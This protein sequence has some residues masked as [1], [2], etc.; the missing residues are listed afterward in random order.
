MIDFSLDSCRV[1]ESVHTLIPSCDDEYSFGNEERRSFLRGWNLTNGTKHD[2]NSSI[3]QA[4]VYRSSDEI[5]TYIYLGEH[6]TYRSGGYVYEL[7]GT[8]NQTHADLLELHQLEWIDKQTRAVLIQMNL[9]NPSIPIF[10]SAIIII[11]LLPSSGVF[12][13]A[14][15]EPLYF[16]CILL[17]PL[18]MLLTLIS[19][20]L[21]FSFRISLSNRLRCDLLDLH[22]LFPGHGNSL[23]Y[24]PS[25]G[26]L[27][28]I[29]VLYWTGCDRLF[30]GGCRYPYVASQWSNKDSE[31]ISFDQRWCLR[32]FPTNCLHQR[33]FLLSTGILLLFWNAEIA[34]FMPLQ[35]SV[36][37]LGEYIETGDTRTAL[38][39]L[40]VFHHFHGFPGTLLLA[41][42]FADMG[43]LQPITYCSNALWNASLEVW[44][45]WIRSGWT[46]L[47]SHLFHLIHSL[48]C[49]R[50]HQYVRVDHQWQF[51]CRSG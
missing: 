28:S 35:P 8:L 14:R 30:M 12:P 2:Y 11:E 4:F 19:V 45:Q 44:H 37:S 16:N 46:L 41:I 3:D 23:V 33:R 29:L 13:S 51:P 17:F 40:H 18:S 5:D 26:V 20:V 21:L 31:V 22:H 48:R 27:S 1:K 32:E 47:R 38:I 7:R 43:M 9:Y 15:F 49:F 24:S 50:L 42:R 25:K 6:A 10:T 36:G 39:L 34:P